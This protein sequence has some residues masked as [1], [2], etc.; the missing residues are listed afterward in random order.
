MKPLLWTFEKGFVC[1][2]G[3]PQTFSR[4]GQKISREGGQEHTFCLK[5][6]LFFT[7]KSKNILFLARGGGRGARTSPCLPPPDA[8]NC[9]A[10]VRSIL[11]CFNQ[12]IVLKAKFALFKGSEQF[13]CLSFTTLSLSLSH[14]HTLLYSLSPS[15]TLSLSILHHSPSLSHTHT[16]AL[17]LTPLSLSLTHTLSPS[18]LHHSPSL[19]LTHSLF[20][21]HSLTSHTL[22]K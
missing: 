11:L 7:L 22:F 6:I 12:T 13:C 15:H 4:G 18:I 1:E 20:L 5:N 9:K 21:S 8:H 3:R 2:H 14:T 19:S 16:L 10:K 17:Y